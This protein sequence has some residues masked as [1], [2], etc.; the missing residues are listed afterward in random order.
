[1]A[2][3][4]AG[5]VAVAGDRERGRQGTDLNRS[6]VDL[7]LRS[8]KTDKKMQ[9][10]DLICSGQVS[11]ALSGDCRTQST[12]R[13]ETKFRPGLSID[14]ID[15]SCRATARSRFLPRSAASFAHRSEE[16]TS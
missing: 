16:H 15:S 14:E 4:R 3:G 6:A 7:P 10:T 11:G 13:G 12:G 9:G 5:S 1:M 8:P 2:H